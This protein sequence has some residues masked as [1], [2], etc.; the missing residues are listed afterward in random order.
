MQR[1]LWRKTKTG[2]VP[3]TGSAVEQITF[4]AYKIYL[5]EKNILGLGAL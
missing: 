5:S 4:I 1:S 3:L 2:P